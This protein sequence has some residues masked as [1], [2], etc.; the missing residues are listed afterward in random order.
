MMLVRRLYRSIIV[1]FLVSIGGIAAIDVWAEPSSVQSLHPLQTVA[2]YTVYIH[3]L[4]A[5]YLSVTYSDSH[6]HYDATVQGK[7]VGLIGL[8]LPG[9]LYMHA[10]GGLTTEGGIKPETFTSSGY[11]HHQDQQLKMVYKGDLPVVTK[12]EPQ[13]VGREIISNR[14][15]TGAVDTLAALI[16]VLRQVEITHRCAEINGLVFDGRRLSTLQVYPVKNTSFV[17]DVLNAPSKEALRCDFVLHQVLG[18]MP[19]EPGKPSKLHQLQP[20][21]IWFQNVPTIGIV[22]S[23]LE[24][25]HP[26][27]GHII[28]V[29]NKTS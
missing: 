21:R 6:K 15:R 13:D 8:F 18:F 23:R 17:V 11:F 27:M 10:E 29:L 9:N 28:L 3:G 22:P 24:L 26:K 4:R 1:V 14:A 20:G 16:E 7:T 2:H 25:N 19:S 5:M 12:E